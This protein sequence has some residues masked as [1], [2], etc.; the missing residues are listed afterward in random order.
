MAVEV[1]SASENDPFPSTSLR[2]Q[3]DNKLM[4]E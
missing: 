3:D 2:G 4:P 1:R